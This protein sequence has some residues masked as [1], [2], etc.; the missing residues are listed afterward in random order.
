MNLQQ[1]SN[2]E[3]QKKVGAVEIPSVYEFIGF[4]D[5]IGLN[6]PVYQL[7]FSPCIEID[8]RLSEKYWSQG[9][10]TEA[11]QTALVVAFKQFA[12]R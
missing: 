9:F 1:I 2:S 3:Y 5:F 10:A 11:A 12:L 6:K 7:P 8:W 4:I